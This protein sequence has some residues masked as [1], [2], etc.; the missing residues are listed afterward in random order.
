VK[1]LECQYFKNIFLNIP[2]NEDLIV[3]KNNNIIKAFVTK[4]VKSVWKH[5]TWNVL[6]TLHVLYV[7]QSKI[8]IMLHILDGFLICQ[9]PKDLSYKI[10][11]NSMIFMVVFICFFS[12]IVDPHHPK[13]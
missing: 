4:F 3:W 7:K 2:L 10:S 11:M 13:A 6:T 9:Y 5:Y 1:T 8:S 12:K